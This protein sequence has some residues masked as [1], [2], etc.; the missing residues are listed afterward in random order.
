MRLVPGNLLKDFVVQPKAA[1][2]KKANG[3]LREQ[4]R[5]DPP[6][7]FRAVLAN[8]TPREIEQWRQMQHPITHTIVQRGAPSAQAED[9]LVLDD[10][11][12]AVW[13]VNNIGALGMYTIYFVE[14]R[15]N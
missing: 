15:V 9:R 2:V 8:A 12:F 11:V 13:G 14:E 3:R 1:S 5:T 7:R 6:V 10:R 4:H